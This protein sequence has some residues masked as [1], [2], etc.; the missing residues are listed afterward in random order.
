MNKKIVLQISAAFFLFMMT[1][2]ASAVTITNEN[3]QTLYAETGFS[4]DA[5][6]AGNDMS[7]D[8]GQYPP[9]YSRM[10]LAINDIGDAGDEVT[11]YFFCWVE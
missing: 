3:G 9:I 4:K 11:L 1:S 8:Y 5:P 2:I 7:V 10:Y 6:T